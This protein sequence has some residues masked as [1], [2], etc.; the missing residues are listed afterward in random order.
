MAKTSIKLATLS[1]QS[2]NEALTG[3]CSSEPKKRVRKLLKEPIWSI[4]A[5]HLVEGRN[6]F[7]QVRQRVMMEA[8][9]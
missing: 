9:V 3:V 6:Q 1:I 2:S 4:K 7:F 5:L 8:K